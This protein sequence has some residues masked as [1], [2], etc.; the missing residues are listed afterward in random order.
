M[1]D[2]KLE[3]TVELEADPETVWEAIATGPGISTW[4]VPCEVEQR[5]G[6]TVAQRFG[7]GFDVMGTV[8]AFEPG[9]RFAYSAAEPAPD[10]A[11]NYAFEFLVEGRDGGGTVLRFVQ[12][13]F[14][15]TGWEDEYDS[16]DAGWA[17]FFGNL[18]AYLAHFAGMPVRTAVAMTYTPG[19]AAEVWPVL[20]RE[21]GLS[22]PPAVGDEVALAPD[23]PSP[24]TG[25]VDVANGEFLG[26]RSATGLHRIGAEGERGCGVSAYHYFYG[27]PV[28]VDAL[29]DAWQAWLV[30]RFPSA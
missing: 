6:G 26:V 14:L 28:D 10:G 19:S 3:K 7:G 8:T 1:T 21:L 17:L 25:V 24:V 30:E 18:R 20:H 27:D 15:E 16:F 2:R 12:S 22:G 13:G 9:R 5:A 29:G 4:F 11:A 23:G